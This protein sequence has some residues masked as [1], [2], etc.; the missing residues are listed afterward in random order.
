MIQVSRNA[1]RVLL[2][3]AALAVCLHG[4]SG[5]LMYKRG[6]ARVR[7]FLSCAGR[8]DVLFLGDSQMLC[9]VMPM[10]LFRDYGIASY[11]LSAR[12][13]TLPLEYWL[14]RNALRVS[15]PSLVVLGIPDA[16]PALRAPEK[17]ED[18]QT[19]MDAWPMSREKALAVLDLT[20][21]R[22]PWSGLPCVFPLIRYHSRWS[23]LGPEDLF[24]KPNAAMGAEQWIGARAGDAYELTEEDDL[25]PEEGEAFG[26]LR[27]ILELCGVRGAEVLLVHMPWPAAPERQRAVNT[28]REI[29]EE[30]GASLVDFPRMDGVIDP[31]TDMAD[32]V[33]HLN[34]SGAGKVTDYLGW[35]LCENYDLPDHRG[36]E[37]F[38]DWAARG[39]YL[40]GKLEAVRGAG[41]LREALALAHDRDFSVCVAVREGALS[42]RTARFLQ[43]IPRD[44]LLPGY[45]EGWQSGGMHPLGLLE[46]LEDGG[47]GYFMAADRESGEVF[48]ACGGEEAVFG[49]SFGELRV[50]CGG[51]RS[52]TRTLGGV[53][54][55]WLEAG[56]E[57]DVFLFVIDDRTGGLAVKRS[58]SL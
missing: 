20:A 28:M 57:G 4:L 26:Y 6:P 45:E 39:A 13:A 17:A 1:L 18:L 31:E 8:A 54:E 42:G 47:E 36:D 50:R 46:S 10:D 9:G 2:F 53:A 27:K 7:P 16:D 25:L 35:M 15:S 56:E 21:D 12:N 32:A 3:L 55:T 51:E 29:A 49:A 58:W 11:N 22:E 41:K 5:L 48:E 24:P 33:T 40:D 38:A 14:L 37:A 23:G 43:N 52:V 19:A 44:H 34:P 30:Y